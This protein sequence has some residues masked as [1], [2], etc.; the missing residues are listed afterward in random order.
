[1]GATAF[2]DTMQMWPRTMAMAV[3]RESDYEIALA[4]ELWEVDE[5]IGWVHGVRAPVWASRPNLPAGTGHGSDHTWELMSRMVHDAMETG[6]LP[7]RVVSGKLKVS[8]KEFV[9]WCVGKGIE[10]PK[11]LSPLLDGADGGRDVEDRCVDDLVA[12][13]TALH[14]TSLR[15]LIGILLAAVF[16]KAKQAT[17]TSTS[18]QRSAYGAFLKEQFQVKQPTLGEYLTQAGAV[19]KRGRPSKKS[20]N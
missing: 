8:R 7:H 13:A 16:C 15:R 9:A 10:L 19:R 12:R 5:A 17:C 20:Q 1:M 14:P 18:F 3:A 11:E 4:I 6:A 2:K